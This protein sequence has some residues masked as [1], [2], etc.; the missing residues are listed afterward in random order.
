MGNG[1]SLLQMGLSLLVY[2]LFSTFFHY[3]LPSPALVATTAAVVSGI[4]V[5]VWRVAVQ[6]QSVGQ[7]VLRGLTLAIGWMAGWLLAAQ[8]H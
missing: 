4:A 6:K 3:F 5:A 2:C 8:L 1:V 7:A